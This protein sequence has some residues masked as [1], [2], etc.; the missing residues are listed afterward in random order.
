MAQFLSPATADKLR[1]RLAAPEEVPEMLRQSTLE[2]DLLAQLAALRPVEPVSP[3]LAIQG[4]LRGD[5]CGIGYL[6]LLQHC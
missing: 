2:A 1:A 6:S 5:P 4:S 3:Q